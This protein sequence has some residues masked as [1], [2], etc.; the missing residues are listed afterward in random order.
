MVLDN[1]VRLA[2]VPIMPQCLPSSNTLTRSPT[3]NLK[4]LAMNCLTTVFRWLSQVSDT[5]VPQ[6][7]HT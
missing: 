1:R 2:I 7:V 4:G 5:Q 6:V 3:L